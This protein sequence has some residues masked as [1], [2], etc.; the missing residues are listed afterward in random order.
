MPKF[1]AETAA[2][3]SRKHGPSLQKICQF[4]RNDGR[5]IKFPTKKLYGKK[6]RKLLTA[7]ISFKQEKKRKQENEQKKKKIHL[8]KNQKKIFL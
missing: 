3:R 1:S 6:F 8:R 4:C 7:K 2:R 5:K